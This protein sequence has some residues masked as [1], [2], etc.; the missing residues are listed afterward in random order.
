M[1][2]FDLN[3]VIR[4]VATYTL[5]ANLIIL[6]SSF[7]FDTWN[8]VT[9]PT[10]NP[11]GTLQWAGI[12]SSSDGTQIAASSYEEVWLSSNSGVT[13]IRSTPNYANYRKIASS[14]DGSKLLLASSNGSHLQRSTD[15]GTSWTILGGSVVQSWHQVAS[16]A[17]GQ[18]LAAAGLHGT[19]LYISTDGG[20][21]WSA[22]DSANWNGV[23][24]SDNG[25]TIVAVAQSRAI[26]VST[27]S[28]TTW[29]NRDTARGWSDVSISNDGTKIIAAVGEGQIYKSV[30]TGTT[31]TVLSNS[32]SR[33]YIPVACSSDCSTIVV[34]TN[35]EGVY[36]S[37]DSG[38]NWY[39][40]L[41]FPVLG[42]AP[43]TAQIGWV[44]DVAISDDGAK[45]FASP[46]GQRLYLSAKAA[47]PA[48]TVETVTATGATTA[49]VSFTAPR[50]N[51][52]SVITSYTATSN[53]GDVIG[54]VLQAGSGTINVSGLNPSTAYRFTVKAI[55]SIGSSSASSASA[56]VTTNLA[57]PVFSL[58]S[59]SENKTVNTTISGYT[60]TS[61]GGTIASYAISPVAPAGLTFD[62]TTGLLTGTPTSVASATNYTITATNASGNST[63]TFTLTVSSAPAPATS[64]TAGVITP[65]PAPTKKQ[66]K[67]VL[68]VETTTLNWLE[69]TPI[70]LV[71]GVESGSVTYQ[72]SG[73]AFCIIDAK[74]NLLVTTT[75][76]ICII[77][78]VNSGDFEYIWEQSNEIK[79]SVTAQDSVITETK[80]VKE[81]KKV[82]E[83][84]S[85]VVEQVKNIL[86]MEHKVTFGQSAAWINTKNIV[87]IRNFI[88][89]AA[90]K[91][92]I[93]KIVIKGFS[94]PTKI[95]I[96]NIDIARANTVKNFLKREGIDYPIVATGAGEAK[97]K[98][99]ELSRIAIVT[100][101]GKPKSLN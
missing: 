30:D 68:T 35:W 5:F 89:K 70:R 100:I 22:K 48:P 12:T 83:A 44:N 81:E 64:S 31:W 95:S 45:A 61:T 97:A 57:A 19:A 3:R 66:P 7:A 34:G 76:G 67:M 77:T 25:A 91:I 88:S 26:Y 96:P 49:T 6:P 90:E 101:E 27:D 15:T 10:G 11:T 82:E 38:E 9:G 37:S 93:E 40:S 1:G 47:P 69:T 73:D 29:S 41:P 32:P 33:K 13:W 75:P 87:A 74:S 79:I 8:P 20:T 78:A 51:G 53:P 62:T 28:G 94:Q 55:N 21:N 80:P 85:V 86:K 23:A 59:S 16:S 18:V 2:S 58:S 60:I 17:N 84:K 65:A 36:Y 52:G 54:T 50:T 99:S 71:G 92:E 39:S 24:I 14:S 72:N 98:K 63:A 43:V 42:G 46:Y 4:F 56:S